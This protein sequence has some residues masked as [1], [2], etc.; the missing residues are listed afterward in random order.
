MLGEFAERFRDTVKRIA[1]AGH[2]VARIRKLEFP[3][4]VTPLFLAA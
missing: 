2:E 4:H 3:A 1:R